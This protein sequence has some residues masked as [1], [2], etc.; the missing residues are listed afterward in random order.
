V[1]Q[2]QMHDAYGHHIDAQQARQMIGLY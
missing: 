1:L 2:A